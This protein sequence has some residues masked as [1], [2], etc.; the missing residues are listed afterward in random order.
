M[1]P[2]IFST[3]RLNLRRW[4]YSDILPCIEMNEDNEVM[5]FF[6]KTQTADETLAMVQRINARFEEN[7]FGFYVV[8][9]KSTKYF[10][11]FTGFG[12]P[13][14]ESFFTPCIEIGWRFKKDA[15]GKGYAT[16][17]AAGCLRYGF[18][19]LQFDKIVSFTSVLN[20]NSEKVMQRIGMIRIGEFDHPLIEPGDSL[21]RHVLYELV[22]KKK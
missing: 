6:P 18:E 14:F 2:Y 8:E 13:T 12:I 9:E 7:G 3:E 17:A 5:K 20:T 4:I 11:G 15:W 22:N 21:C 10:L 16:E 19:T 1:V